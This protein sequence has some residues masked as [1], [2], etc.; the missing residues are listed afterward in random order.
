MTSRPTCC[1]CDN[2]SN[3]RRPIPPWR[4]ASQAAAFFIFKFCISIVSAHLT[5]SLAPLAGRKDKDSGIAY[6]E[7]VQRISGLFLYQHPS[8]HGRIGKQPWPII[9]QNGR[10]FS[11]PGEIFFEKKGRPGRRKK[12][13]QGCVVVRV[14]GGVDRPFMSR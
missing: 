6:A 13:I 8:V 14:R 5:I 7:T 3:E 4:P 2:T 12:R 9:T 10:S 1:R 11:M